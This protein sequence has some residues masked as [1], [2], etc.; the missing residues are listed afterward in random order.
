MG[1]QDNLGANLRSYVHGFSPAVR[2]I[3]EQFD[4]DT[5]IDRLTKANLLYLVSENAPS[6]TILGAGAGC[7]SV[8]HIYETP[9][10]F[11]G[12]A[13]AT[14]DDVAAN[15]SRISDPTGETALDGA[16]GQTGKF[17]AAA[18]EALGVKLGG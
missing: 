16:F 12:G 5:Q 6:K 15:W 18:A 10:V 1:D 17:A 9:A 4:F 13:G 11:L 7:F 3:F 14:V 2:D 8:V